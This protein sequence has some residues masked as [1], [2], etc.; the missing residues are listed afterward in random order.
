[1]NGSLGLHVRELGATKQS[2]LVR[3]LRSEIAHSLFVGFLVRL[4]CVRLDLV[5]V[6]QTM[7]GPW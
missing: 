3:W 4:N 5:S 1:M 6:E 7:T 2:F